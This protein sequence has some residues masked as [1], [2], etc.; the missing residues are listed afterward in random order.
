MVTRC[1]TIA[2]RISSQE[3]DVKV[4]HPCSDCV[5][6]CRAKA[7]GYRVA[8]GSIAASLMYCLH[9]TDR[10]MCVE[11]LGKLRI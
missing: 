2:K 11:R 6:Y 10:A 5:R 7:L 1:D 4:P 3:G 9:K 8:G